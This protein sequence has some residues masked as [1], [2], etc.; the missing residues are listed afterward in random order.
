MLGYYWV[1]CGW[2][3]LMETGGVCGLVAGRQRY[4]TGKGPLLTTWVA[5]EAG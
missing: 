3:C 1:E 5:E 4:W 2:E